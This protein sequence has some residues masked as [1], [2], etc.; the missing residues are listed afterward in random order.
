MQARHAVLVG[1]SYRTTMQVCHSNIE[2]S[3]VL[4][5]LQNHQFARQRN[6]IGEKMRW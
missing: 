2:Q 1:L 3:A 4:R 5:S 6:K